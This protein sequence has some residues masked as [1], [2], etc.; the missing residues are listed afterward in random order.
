MAGMVKLERLLNLF[1]VLMQATRPLT[2]DEIRASL[3]KGAYA[4]DEVAFLRTFDRDKNDLRDLGVELL[5]E[6]APNEYPPK[7]GY[8]IDREAYGVVMPVL[9]AEEST[10]LALATAIV[11]IDPDFPAVPVWLLEDPTGDGGAVVGMPGTDIPSGPNVQRLMRAVTERRVVGFGYRGEERNVE[12]HR[13][14]FAKG[15]WQLT[16][17]D[18]LR[19]AVRQFRSDRIEGEVTVS[20]ETFDQPEATREVEIDHAWRFGRQSAGAEEA[21][22]VRMR[23][24]ARHVAWLEGFLGGDV[25]IERSDDGTAIVSEQVRDL[26]AFRS[27]ALTFLEGAEII[28]PAEARADMVAWLEAMEGATE[29]SEGGG[30]ACRV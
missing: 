13:L 25:E 22:T 24:D 5:M 26:E 9:D 10:S 6:S 8:R 7:D 12:P 1:T 28:G 30:S 29:D 16:G 21:L 19:D 14:V 23:V 20:D 17:H 11:R 4:T 18:R 27:F 2:R 15:R 3:P